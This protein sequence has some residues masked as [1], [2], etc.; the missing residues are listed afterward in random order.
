MELEEIEHANLLLAL[1]TTGWRVSG[2]NGAA[3]LLDINPSTLTSRIKALGIAPAAR[4]GPVQATSAHTGPQHGSGRTQ[5]EGDSLC[6]THRSA[7]PP[8]G[9]RTR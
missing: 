9:I 1:E 8:P 7:R 3:R 2:E 5:H 4:R 6:V